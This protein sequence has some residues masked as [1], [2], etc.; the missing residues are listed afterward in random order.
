MKRYLT[1]C[2]LSL[3]A[4]CGCAPK[5]P[6]LGFFETDG[7]IKP[8]QK[9][10]GDTLTF[11]LS[12]EIS[13]EF[14][15]SGAGVRRMDVFNFRKSLKLSLYYTFLDSFKDVRFADQVDSN[16]VCVVLYRVRPSWEIKSAS[17]S[18]SGVEGRTVSSTNYQV[19]ALFRYDGVIYKDGE[20]V[21]VL[22]NEVMSEASTYFRSGM[23]D[24]FRDGT[25]QLCGAIYKEVVETEPL[26][27]R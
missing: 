8:Y 23:P 19:A 9:S 16:G 21:S 11:V 25:K 22:D 2:A 26:S 12:Q 4:L 6:I 1:L 15:V 10:F 18:V 27:Y 5:P 14:V 7:Y 20:K 17:T 3:I 13:D 24:T